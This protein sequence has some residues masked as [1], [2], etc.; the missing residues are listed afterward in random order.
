MS[1][2]IH[3]DHHHYAAKWQLAKESEFNDLK[4]VNQAGI[5]YAVLPDGL[6]KEEKLLEIAKYFH[7]Y[8]YKYTDL[9]ALGHLP[10]MHYYNVDT[11][12][13][14]KYFL[15]PTENPDKRSF[16]KVAK[17]LHLAFPQQSPTEIYDILNTLLLRCVKKFDPNYGIK[18]QDVVKIVQKILKK[19]CFIVQ[20]IEKKVKFDPVGPIRWLARNE[21]IKAVRGPGKKLIGYKITKLWPPAPDVFAKPVGFVYFVQTWFR[22]YLQEYIDDQMKTLEVRAWEKLLQLEHR[23]VSTDDTAFTGDLPSAEGELVDAQGQGWAAD[24]TLMKKSFDI[25][26]MTPGWIESTTDKHFA[27]MTKLERKLLYLY[28]VQEMPWKQIAQTLNMSINQVQKIHMDIIT[29]L[30]GKFLYTNQ[31]HKK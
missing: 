11:R 6:A 16:A 8:V 5:D 14:L 3:L 2:S 12:R 29:F 18:V 1:K 7:G 13:F 9:I 25:S 19:K 27:K 30:Q 17:H 26:Q 4:T 20:D 24:L 28:W 31:K 15:P 21:Y 22:Y 10:Q 23:I